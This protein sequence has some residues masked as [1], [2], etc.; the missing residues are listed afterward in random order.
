MS[1]PS[2]KQIE[3]KG[4][5]DEGNEGLYSLLHKLQDEISQI[6]DSNGVLF[7]ATANEMEILRSENNNLTN[8]L[9]KLKTDF[10]TMVVKFLEQKE[11]I[12]ELET[13][14]IFMENSH[15]SM[16]SRDLDNDEEDIIYDEVQ[17]EQDESDGNGH[18][19]TDEEKDYEQT[20][21]SLHTEDGNYV[22]VSSKELDNETHEPTEYM[23]STTEVESH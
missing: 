2:N 5:T 6:R 12:R 21:S 22:A 16:D 20:E 19:R 11:R 10:D 7:R 9:L 15:I 3:G 13:W 4:S 18:K 14:K 8:I 17:E 1:G 23:E